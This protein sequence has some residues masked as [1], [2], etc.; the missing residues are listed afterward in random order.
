MYLLPEKWRE[1]K[2]WRG[3]IFANL[4]FPKV[5]RGFIFANWRLSNISRGFN[6]SNL[7][8]IRENYEHLSMRKLVP[9]RYLNFS[10]WFV[11]FQQSFGCRNCNTSWNNAPLFL[12][13]LD[14]NLK[15]WSTR[16]PN[17]NCLSWNLK[18]ISL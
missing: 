5:L 9:L 10:K 1:E 13:L 18:G 11:S 17:T 7:G 16:S 8:K 3:F 12:H 14:V 2:I 4:L 15:F 6:F